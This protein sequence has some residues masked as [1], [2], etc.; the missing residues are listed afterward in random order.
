MSRFIDIRSRKKGGKSF[1]T[2]FPTGESCFDTDK[3][4]NPDA[5]EALFE[6]RLKGS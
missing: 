5:R 2:P 4:S 3:E 6:I 1:L